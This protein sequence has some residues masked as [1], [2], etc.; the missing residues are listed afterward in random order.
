MSVHDDVRSAR[1]DERSRA[2]R[3]QAIA[4]IAR[5]ELL[6]RLADAR[7]SFHDPDRGPAFACGVLETAIEIYLRTVDHPTRKET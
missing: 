1:A 3:R 7:A 2:N 5:D 4:T 6:D